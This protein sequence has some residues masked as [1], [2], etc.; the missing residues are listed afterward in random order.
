VFENYDYSESFIHKAIPYIM[1][2][3]FYTLIGRFIYLRIKDAVKRKVGSKQKL[4]EVRTK[5]AYEMHQEIG[6]DLNALVYKIKNWHAKNGNSLSEEFK[7]LENTT[8]Q[9]I[10]KVNDI[11]WSLNSEKNNLKELQIHLIT[12]AEQTL[13]NAD[14][15]CTINAI[16]NMPARNIE[17]EVKKNI[18]LLFK[19]A[20]NNI[21]KH[22]HASH[23]EI[24]FKYHL[25]KLQ[26][27]IV[28]NGKGFDA[29]TIIKGNGLDSMHHR[30]KQLKGKMDFIQ[31][32][33]KGTIVKFE[34]KV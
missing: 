12:Y 33:P 23:V 6:N 17:L 10:A 28:D 27:S 21:V 5:I 11:V 13:A 14:L 29:H 16:S 19:E 3:S 4:N 31:N 18:Y 32:Q 30:I 26:I 1:Q 34:L 9:V 15:A 24:Q 20:I 2:W 25:R 22:A 8:V 7:Q